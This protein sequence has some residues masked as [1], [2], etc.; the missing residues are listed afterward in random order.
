M[1]GIYRQLRLEDTPGLHIMLK[2][3]LGLIAI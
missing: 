2:I 1:P 3:S